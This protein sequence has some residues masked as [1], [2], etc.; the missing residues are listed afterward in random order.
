MSSDLYIQ[1]ALSKAR[2]EVDV[3]FNADTSGS[4]DGTIPAGNGWTWGFVL[5]RRTPTAPWI[6]VDDGVG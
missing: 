6:V 3:S 4:P 2:G 1:L 5:A